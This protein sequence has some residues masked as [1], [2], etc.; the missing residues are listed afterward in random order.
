MTVNDLVFV[1]LNG[2]VI[3]LQRD[4]GDL[5]WKW[6]PTTT[7]AGFVAFAVDGDRLFVSDNGYIYCLDAVTGEEQWHNPLTGFGTGIA[8]VATATAGGGQP[9]ASAAAMAAQQAAQS[10]AAAAII[11]ST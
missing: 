7:A 6:S 1:G 11:A 9:A 4:T 10:A 3:A 5:V 2:R 8:V